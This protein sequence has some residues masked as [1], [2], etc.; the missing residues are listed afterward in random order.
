MNLGD[1]S[2]LFLKM[3][4]DTFVF[5]EGFGNVHSYRGYYNEVAF[6][7]KSGVTLLEVKQAINLAYYDEHYGYKGGEYRYDFSTPAHLAMYGC[8]SD[9]SSE[10]LEALIKNM[11]F[12]YYQSH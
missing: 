5:T 6:E 4:D 8:C 12:E 9:E 1:F 11:V 10:N 3:K 7:P 2:D